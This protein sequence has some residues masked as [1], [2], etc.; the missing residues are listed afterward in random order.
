MQEVEQAAFAHGIKAA[1]L[2]EQAGEGIAE[3]VQQFFSTPGT[4]VLYCGKGNNAGDVLVAG[5]FLARGGWK[6]FIRAAF[7]EKE[8]SELAQQQLQC[9]KKEKLFFGE[10]TEKKALSHGVSTS[11]FVDAVT[12]Y[13]TD[14]LARD[15]CFFEKFAKI[16]KKG[17]LVLLDGLLG[18]GAQG[19]PRREIQNLIEEINERRR[20]EGAFVVAADLPSGL[21][22]TTGMPSKSCVEADL[23]VTIAF[24]KTGLIADSATK[25]VGRL[26]IVPL[27]HLTTTKKE[28]AF[29]ITAKRLQALLP[30]R[31]FDV[32]KGMFGRVG[33]IAGSQG[34]LGAARL[35]ST[36][37]LHAGAG[38]V[39][40]YALPEMYELL[41]VSVPPEVMVKP[42]ACYADVL[43]E[44]LDALAIGPGLG[45]E[46]HA[47]ILEIIEK[48]KVPCVVDADALNALATDIKILLECQGPRLLTPHPGEM[49]RLFPRQDRTR[50]AWA[51]DFIKQYPVT[52]LLKGA[53]TIVAEKEKALAYNTSGN[54]G[55][56]SGGMGDVLT[57]VAASFLASGHE[58]RGAAMLG[59]WLCGHAAEI[60]IFQGTASS[61]S[62]VASD[63]ISNLGRAM[64]DLREG[65]F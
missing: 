58:P 48:A 9:L 59:S 51:A 40:L 12:N 52:L 65:V 57:G 22:A 7:S 20:M 27:S 49:E 5:R 55:M 46:H 14:P 47:E 1:D 39:T 32:H 64:Q 15:V 21:E 37:S 10:E 56:A 45:S 34:Y 33:I 16:Q 38:L 44:R 24:S 62:L 19:Q 8:M 54:P 17:P 11:Q 2:M 3:V 30:P 13:G 31:S 53:R 6:I 25:N 4:C 61:E 35:A 41:A 29:L 18:I 43:T 26:A 50:A 60:A 63:V 42:I 28:E 23:T 36:A